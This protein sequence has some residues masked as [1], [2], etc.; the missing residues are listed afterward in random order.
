MA[1]RAERRAALVR[2]KRRAAR[3]Y[4]Y[5]DRA[6]KWANHIQGC[7]GPCC[8]NPRKWFGE[9]TMQERRFECSL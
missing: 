7:S 9:K 6:W 2:M 8:G 5:W 4:P 1:K 3:V